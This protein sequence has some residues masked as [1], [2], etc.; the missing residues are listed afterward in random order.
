MHDKARI[1]SSL[2]I[3]ATLL[4]ATAAMALETQPVLPTSL[5]M[6]A[7][8]VS[9]ESC[10]SQG[11]KVTATVLNQEG[12]L[13]I[14]IRNQGA[15]PHTIENSFNKAYTSVSF[16]RAYN[17]NSTRAIIA[18][19][20]PGKGIGEFPLPASPI[21]GLSYSAGGINLTSNDFLIGSIGV[22]GSP[23]GDLDENCA[24]NGLNAIQAELR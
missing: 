14:V 23:N 3:G 6:K 12:N 24:R 18:S 2:G 15:G 10:A 4:G 21:K 22:S 13:L 11:Y 20:K 16:G 19:T 7:A 9:V 17:L 8:S 5:A 1:I